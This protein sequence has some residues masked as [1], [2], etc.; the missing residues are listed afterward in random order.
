M[1]GHGMAKI[2][3]EEAHPASAPERRRKHPRTVAVNLGGIHAR[4]QLA[5]VEAHAAAGGR[6]RLSLQDLACPETHRLVQP[7]PVAGPCGLARGRGLPIAHRGGR[8]GRSGAPWHERSP[9]SEIGSSSSC[10]VSL[11]T[12]ANN[13][14]KSE[15][16]VGKRRLAVPAMTAPGRSATVG[17]GGR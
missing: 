4:L 14:I 8:R 12:A 1:D 6:R 11:H 9:T 10:R 5:A 13:P 3:W 15:P 16:A 2:A 7:D 17:A